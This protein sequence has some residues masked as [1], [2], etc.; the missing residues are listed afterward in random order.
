MF[1]ACVSPGLLSA[2]VCP[3]VGVKE[4]GVMVPAVGV[5]VQLVTQA[6]E[7]SQPTSRVVE[8]E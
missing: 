5:P 4:A 1:K 8:F 3:K 7:A 2:T 6:I